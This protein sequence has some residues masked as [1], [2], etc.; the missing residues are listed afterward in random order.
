MILFADFLSVSFD[1]LVCHSHSIVHFLVSRGFWI[2]ACMS[3][4]WD[5]V[6][7]TAAMG[8]VG[9]LVCCL[10]LMYSISRMSRLYLTCSSILVLNCLFCLWLSVIS[11]ESRECMLASRKVLYARRAGGHRRG[12]LFSLWHVV[13]QL[14]GIVSMRI[15]AL[16]LGLWIHLP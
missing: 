1:F 10:G 16:G 14:L 6:M 5:L 12:H 11:T 7:M 4:C 2:C 15:H 3:W 13:D 8:L 9:P